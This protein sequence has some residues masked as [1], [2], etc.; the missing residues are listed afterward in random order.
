ME[1]FRYPD[2]SG[3]RPPQLVLKET[4]AR[5][6]FRSVMN[7]QT[8]RAALA[9]E[10]GLS[11]TTVSAL[12]DE[13]IAGGLLSEAGEAAQTKAGRRPTLLEI[14]ASGGSIAVVFLCRDGLR[15]TVC[16]LRQR[17]LGSSFL[18]WGEPLSP[19]DALTALL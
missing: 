10:H 14:K 13:M 11:P 3:K 8:S 2:I 1:L 17:A 5:R 18:P 6:L 7:G 4:N 12:I 16:D 15:L 9:K 19:A